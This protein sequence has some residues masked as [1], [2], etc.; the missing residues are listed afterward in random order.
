MSTS[1]LEPTRSRD[2]A[3]RD[4]RTSGLMLVAGMVLL[5]WIVEVIDAIADQR[6]DQFGIVPRQIDGLDGIVFSPFLHSGFGHLLANTVPFLILGAVIA[7]N[8]AVR[9]LQVTVIVGLVAGIGTWL[10]AGSNT[11]TVGASGIVMGY[12]TYLVSRGVFSRRAFELI[13][14]VVIAVVWGGMVLT[15]L[16]PTEGVSWQAHLFGAIGGV[17][18]AW[19]LTADRPAA[20]AARRD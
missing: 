1:T 3:P 17:V 4:P 18:A 2:V 11:V 9:V 7:L 20:E 12:A 15:S 5:M 16:T 6:L 19:M 10:F 14:G 8:G 13:V